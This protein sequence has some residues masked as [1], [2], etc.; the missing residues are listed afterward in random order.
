LLPF[1]ASTPRQAAG[2]LVFL[3]ALKLLKSQDL[4]QFLRHTVRF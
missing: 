3:A 1:F 2:A 4:E